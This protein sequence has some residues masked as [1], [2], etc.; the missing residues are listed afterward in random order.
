[1]HPVGSQTSPCKESDRNAEEKQSLASGVKLG[2]DAC[3][4]VLGSRD[5]RSISLISQIL[6]CSRDFQPVFQLLRHTAFDP[7]LDIDS[8][9]SNK[10]NLFIWC[11]IEKFRLSTVIHFLSLC[12]VQ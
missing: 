7:R 4:P 12:L 10:G 11:S 8:K 6:G 1:M 9:G 5:L 2:W 3:Q